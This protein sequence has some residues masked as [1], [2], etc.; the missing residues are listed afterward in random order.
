MSFVL[1]IFTDASIISWDAACG[2]ESIGGLW[3]DDECSHHINYLELLAAYFGL[4]SFAGERSGSY[5]LLRI[6]NTT[7]IAYIN[8][9]GGVFP[10]LN[11]MARII[12]S[13]CEERHI[14]IFAS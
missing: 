11:G 12:W 4:K 10:H 7:A 2:D 1:E 8:R 13:W 5:I 14:F 9:M 6:D 3:T